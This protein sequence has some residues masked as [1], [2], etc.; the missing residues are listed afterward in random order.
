MKSYCVWPGSG[1][2]TDY[3]TMVQPQPTPQCTNNHYQCQCVRVKAISLN[4]TNTGFCLKQTK[5]TQTAH[6]Y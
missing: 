3:L 5:A 4:I 2:V 1:V 6:R